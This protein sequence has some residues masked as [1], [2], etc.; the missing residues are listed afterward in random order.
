MG[1][2]TKT[3]KNRLDKFYH[4]AKD[5]GY[6]SRASFKLVQ[7]N[8]K[9]N[10]LANARVLVDLCAAPGSWLQVCAK[11]MPANKVL[12]G[13]DLDKIKPIPGVITFVGDITTVQCKNEIQKH[14]NGALAD[15]VLHDGAPNVGGA[16]AHDAFG[17]SELVLASLKLATQ[18]LA[19]G[20]TFVTKVFRSADYNALLWVFN[21]LFKKVTATKPMASRNTSAE[22][23]VVCEHYLRPKKLDPRLLDP[24]YVFQEI[25]QSKTLDIFAKK[26]PKPNRDGYEDDETQKGFLYKE[27]D[28]LDFIYSEDPVRLLSSYNAIVFKEAPPVVWVDRE[29][30]EEDDAEERS[31]FRSHPLTKDEI[32]ECLADLKVLNA[33]DFKGVLRWRVAMREFAMGDEKED[34]KEEQEEEKIELTEEQ[35]QNLVQQELD[36]QVKRMARLRKKKLAKKKKQQQ[37]FQ[38]RMGLATNMGDEEFDA[39]QEG[40]LF[41]LA[42]VKG[43]DALDKLLGVKASHLPISD[44]GGDVH[45][46]DEDI[47]SFE[48]DEDEETRR[49]RKAEAR[50]MEKDFKRLTEDSGRNVY[51]NES[52]E[53]SESDDEVAAYMGEGDNQKR[54]SLKDRR[55]EKALD[56]MY[57]VVRVERAQAAKRTNLQRRIL[58]RKECEAQNLQS[59]NLDDEEEEDDDSVGYDGDEDP[60]DLIIKDKVPTKHKVDMWFGKE[61]F[62]GLEADDEEDK[63]IEMMLKERQQRKKRKLDDIESQEEEE[64]EEDDDEEMETPKKAENPRKKQKTAEKKK[65]IEEDSDSEDVPD[66]F[67]VVPSSL[68]NFDDYDSDER[69]EMLAM[70]K[71]LMNK[72]TR[73][74]VVESGFNRYAFDDAGLELPSWF[75]DDETAHTQPLIPI[76]KEEVEEE[77]RLQR[78]IDA[79]STKKVAEARARKK[80]QYTAKLEK[81]KKKARSLSESS[82]LSEREKIKAIQKLYKGTLKNEKKEKVYVVARKQGGQSRV[83]KAS[84]GKNVRVKV[85]D[86]RMK[87]DKRGQK[88][89]TKKGKKR[90]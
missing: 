69:A 53:E 85:V 18:F 57:N 45:F 72:K 27:I 73:N 40:S 5:Q 23:F 65:I 44:F 26:A 12:I 8:K 86:P 37:R 74:Q 35:Q 1:K 59:M 9:F 32:T 82:E 25:K 48:D 83:A 29:R 4:L 61:G 81:T 76:T 24:K 89:R 75:L 80:N 31:L 36:D 6:R 22:I 64:G 78:E 16:W 77:K 54:A 47:L 49:Q 30:D 71:K 2:K 84:Q 41:A 62:E 28:V 79:R 43:G 58:E 42:S 68:P 14:T 63:A 66:S 46:G 56:L 88:Q 51:V 52:S 38:M 3:G 11:Y 19:Q 39:P 10:F 87:K 17:Q 15:V 90:G 70:G 13:V 55:V 33:K 50:L 20:G 67:E 7:L 34:E 60:N 21:T